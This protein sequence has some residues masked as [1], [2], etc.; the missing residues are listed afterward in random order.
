MGKFG[1]KNVE[2]N[3]EIK[4]QTRELEKIYSRFN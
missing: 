2:K 3:F 1:R 4:K